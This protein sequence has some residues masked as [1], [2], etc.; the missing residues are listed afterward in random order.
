MGLEGGGVRE[1]T[2]GRIFFD[3]LIPFRPI[4]ACRSFKGTSGIDV[5]FEGWE[6]GVMED[7]R[8][9]GDIVAPLNAEEPSSHQKRRNARAAWAACNLW[10]RNLDQTENSNLQ[11]TI[12]GK[13]GSDP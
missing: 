4:E 6:V 10:N 2:G 5:N 3:V 11:R 12:S 8:V 9:K 1:F 7:R 13:S